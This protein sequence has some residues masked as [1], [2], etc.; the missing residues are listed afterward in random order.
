MRAAKETFKWS[1]KC[2]NVEYSDELPEECM[3]CWRLNSFSR[4]TEEVVEE[5]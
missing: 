2:G 4:M 3:Q 5:D 1:C